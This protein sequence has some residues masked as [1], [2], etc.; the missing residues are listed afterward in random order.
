MRFTPVFSL[1]MRW[2]PHSVF[3]VS[4]GLFSAGRMVFLIALLAAASNPA[5]G[6]GDDAPVLA[7]GGKA[8]ARIVI[9][10]QASATERFAA[11][12]LRDYLEKISGARLDIHPETE[13]KAESGMVA[14]S[15]RGF[16]RAG[17]A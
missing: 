16:A 12:E 15:R 14:S 13:T 3:V 6:L 17:R 10:R 2:N 1:L 11:E 9:P 5:T 8:L 7:D 4:R